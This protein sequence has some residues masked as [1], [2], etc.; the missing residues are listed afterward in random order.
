MKDYS[1]P[2]LLDREGKL[3][4]AYPTQ[5]GKATLIFLEG[6]KIRKI[7]YLNSVEEIRQALQLQ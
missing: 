7:D 1:F 3:T 6:L 2:V 4:S 5:E